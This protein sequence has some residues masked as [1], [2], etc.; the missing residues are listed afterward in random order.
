MKNW[1]FVAKIFCT[2]SLYVAAHSDAGSDIRLGSSIDTVVVV[3]FSHTSTPFIDWIFLS[4][5][6]IKERYM[7][8]D[9]TSQQTYESWL[10][11]SI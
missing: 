3:I 8:V 5:L 1:F 10:H 7:N 11:G 4:F 6:F 2:S 9:I